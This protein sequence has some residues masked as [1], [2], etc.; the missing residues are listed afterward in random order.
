[1]RRAFRHAGLDGQARL[2]FT[3]CLGPCSE[4]NVVFLYMDGRPLWLRRMNTFE[5]FVELL[6]WMRKALARR[7]T[8]LPPALSERAF[9]WTGSGPGPAPPIEG[10]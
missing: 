2:A 3:D 8:P 7:E 5:P 10:T 4:A 9:A 6:D 1:M